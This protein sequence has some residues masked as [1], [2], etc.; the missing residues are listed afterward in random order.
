MVGQTESLDMTLLISRKIDLD[1]KGLP[2]KELPIASPSLTGGSTTT[3]FLPRKLCAPTN[4]LLRRFSF[5]SSF[6][7]PLPGAESA[8]LFSCQVINSRPDASQNTQRLKKKT[9]SIRLR[10]MPSF[11]ARAAKYFGFDLDEPAEEVERRS[12]VLRPEVH[13]SLVSLVEQQPSEL[14]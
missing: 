12:P 13:G 1:L 10:K 3:F 2:V 8:F 11:G 6:N 4:V 5:F 14:V 7:M 9:S